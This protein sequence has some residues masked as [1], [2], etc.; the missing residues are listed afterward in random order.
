MKKIKIGLMG[1]A[2]RMG[3]EIA[4]V[5]KANPRCELVYAPLRAEKWDSKK[6]NQV[7]VW[8]DF[9][10]PEAL[11]DVLKKA[12]EAKTPVVC[13]TT[14]FSK[15]EKELLKT[16][17]KKIPVLWSSN[18]SLGVAVLNE[19][20]KAF[21]AISHFDFQ[22]EEIHHNRKKDRPSGTAITLQENLEKAV[23]KKLPEALA[24]RGGGVFGVHKIFAMS[25][26]EVLTFEHTALNRTVFAKGS[27]QAAEW[28]VKQKPGLYQIRDVL[29]G[30]NK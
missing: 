19:A 11:K 5:I 16:Y 30:K 1:S 25:D 4:G 21:S 12:S 8:I 17:S 23:D 3:Q 13:G 9:T 18:M 2:G 24:I 22:I 20:L 27:V 29:F 14:G 15:K 7:D 26:E 6:A 28:L 10:S